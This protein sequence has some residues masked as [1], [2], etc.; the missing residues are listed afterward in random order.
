M[1][2]GHPITERRFTSAIPVLRDA[3]L[4][5]SIT[6]LGAGGISCAAG[7]M[8]AE[9]GVQEVVLVRRASVNAGVYLVRI[10]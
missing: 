3:G 10:L 7:E 8:G 5:R 6:D 9:T 4:I 2:I 1:Q